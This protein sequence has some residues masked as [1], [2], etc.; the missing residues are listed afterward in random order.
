MLGPEPG[1]SPH[2]WHGPA[3]RPN[4]AFD[5]RLLVHAGMGPGGLLCRLAGDA[6]WSSLAAASPWGAE[7]LQWSSR[8][9]IG[10][11]QLG[12]ND[13]PFRGSDL[14]VSTVLA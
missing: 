1:R 3:L 10:H 9:A 7:R 13:R 5:V 11:G 14:V 12:A 6:T 4:Q 2:T 8:W